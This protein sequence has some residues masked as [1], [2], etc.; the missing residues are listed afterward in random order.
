M[1][2]LWVTLNSCCQQTPAPKDDVIFTMNVEQCAK[3]EIAG[4]GNANHSKDPLSD[5]FP[6][7]CCEG[8]RKVG[9]RELKQCLINSQVDD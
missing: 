4:M 7:R 8:Q 6:F 5:V 2:A 1:N 9:T 3:G